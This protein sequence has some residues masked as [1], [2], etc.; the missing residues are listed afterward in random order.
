MY[1]DEIY[2]E[3]YQKCSKEH[4]QCYCRCTGIIVFLQFGQPNAQFIPSMT[5]SEAEGYCN[6]GFF[7]PGSM[8]PK[9]QSAVSFARSGG[10]TIIASLHMAAEA[11]RGEA[12]TV[13]LPD[14]GTRQ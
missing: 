1:L 11:L 2:E 14:P 6:Q 5:A 10:R 4:H 7:A 12:G 13:I 3:Q 9:V 8:L